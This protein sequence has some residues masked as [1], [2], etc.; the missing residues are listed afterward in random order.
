[1]IQHKN[2]LLFVI[3]VFTTAI[4]VH[5]QKNSRRPPNIIFIL[6]DDLGYGDLGCYGQ[7]YI[8]TPNLDQLA[9]D[10]MR[11]T[12]FYAGSTVCSPSRASLMTGL[13][14]GHSYIR[15]NGEVP[16]RQTDTILPQI[17]KQRGYVNGIVGKW[18]LGQ[19]KT[20][21]AP[22]KKGWDYFVGDMSNVEGHFQ[23]GDSV[24]KIIGGE[25]IKTRIDQST[26]LNELF[27]SS[28]IDF[29]KQMFSFF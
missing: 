1:M 8:K 21:G 28:A 24:W 15:G 14:Q 2:Y 16:L 6:A 26:Y 18:G 20:S 12:N 13:H 25:S 23:Q 11:F 5:A 22:E 3:M 4:Y 7:Q 19:A 10:G 29:I 27:T 17:L 9:R